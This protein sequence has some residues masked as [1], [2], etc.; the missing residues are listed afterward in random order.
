M[1]PATSA[2]LVEGVKLAMQICFTSMKLAGKT[3]TEIDQLF[4]DEKAKFE[5]NRPEDLPDV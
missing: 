5:A 3:D 4:W 1:D 2:L